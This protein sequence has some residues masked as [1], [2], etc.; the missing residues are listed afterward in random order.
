M[1]EISQQWALASMKNLFLEHNM[2]ECDNLYNN[3]VG[4]TYRHA[5][6]NRT[7]LIYLLILMKLI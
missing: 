6:L 5:S 1:S 3:H 7:S 2:V 4:Y